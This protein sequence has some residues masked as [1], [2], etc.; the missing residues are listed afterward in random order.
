MAQIDWA[1][2]YAEMDVRIVWKYEQL[3]RG[4][5]VAKGRRA[6]TLEATNT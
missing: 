3:P 5:Q 6:L 1:T 2:K 4:E